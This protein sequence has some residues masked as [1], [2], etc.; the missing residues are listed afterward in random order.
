MVR[1]GSNGPFVV[2]TDLDDE[3]KASALASG[4]DDKSWSEIDWAN[5]LDGRWCG[6]AVA[7]GAQRDNVTLDASAAERARG[8][9]C[10]TK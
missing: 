10:R 7:P 2:L 8:E 9:S 6:S 3:A 5:P 4:R 1:K